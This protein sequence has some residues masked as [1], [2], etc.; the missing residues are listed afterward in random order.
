MKPYKIADGKKRLK[1]WVVKINTG[2]RNNSGR[3]IYKHCTG[4]TVAEAKEEAK[5]YI[6]ASGTETKT[7]YINDKT[8]LNA[9]N[10]LKDDWLALERER[11]KNPNVGLNPDTVKRNKEWIEC[12]FQIINP[13][14]KLTS[15]DKL[16]VRK[17]LNTLRNS[18][19]SDSKRTRIWR[20]FNQILDS[21][22]MSD[23]IEYNPGKFFK[24]NL[25]KYKAAKKQAHDVDTMRKIYNYL[26]WILDNSTPKRRQAAMIFIIECLT[27]LRWGEVAALTVEDIDFDK[28][29]I[30]VNK[31]R[32]SSDAGFISKTKSS[33]L[34]MS[35][36]NEG[37]RIVAF[38][39][40][41]APLLKHFIQGKRHYL[42]DVKYSTCSDFQ[43]HI[44]KKFNLEYF[45]S[46]SF[47]K[48]VPTQYRKLGADDKDTQAL[49]GHKNKDTQD[50][51]ITYDVPTK[52]TESIW[53]K[54]N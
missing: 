24:K 8:F 34:R 2:V 46:R 25:P 20:Y 19:L 18:D 28:C 23:Y 26:L 42:F 51:Y 7:Q 41:F 9:A 45:T 5:K 37:D 39:K 49:L 29:Y 17:F 3:Y 38:P 36:G 40:Q 27:A 1:P 30:Y 14:T 21:A 12:V 6:V 53:N 22:V 35:E 44:R 4:A 48:F 11:I 33:Q 31:S 10:D 32:S 16:F 52:Y 50:D 47:R 15:V 43:T 54:L 13:K